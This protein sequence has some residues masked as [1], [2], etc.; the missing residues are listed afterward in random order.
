MKKFFVVL[1]VAGLIAACG[2]PLFAGGIEN[3]TNWS[4]EWV[5]TLNRNAATDSADA[6]AYNPAG[7]MKM[8]N[9][10]YL[11]ASGQYAFKDY[12]STYLGTQY[13]T[14]EPDFVP[15]FFTLYKHDKW[16]AFGAV[17]IVVAGGKVD[18]EHGDYTT[19]R[20]ASGIIA[21]YNASL[22]GAFASILD[23]RLEGKS[24]FVGYTLGGAYKINDMLSV[25]LAA[26][27]VDASRD[28]K[29]YATLGGGLLPT[30]TFGVDY[31]ETGNGWGGIFGINITPIEK[32]NIGLRYETKTSID[33][34][35]H[36]TTDD[37]GIVTEGFQR[38]RDL[39]AV[40]GVGVSYK[41]TPKI[42]VEADL[43][44]YF[45]DD[46]SWEDNPIT[47]GN[48]TVKD[49]GY[50]VGIACEYTFN[51]KWKASVGYM[52]TW[53]GINPDN[54]SIETPELDASTIAGGVAYKPAPNWDLNLGVLKTFYDDATTSYGLHF[55]KDVVIVG[56]GI[57]YKFF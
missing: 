55:E 6:V 18:Y 50:D 16:A 56:L 28:F 42:R 35:T 29:G 23:Q 12:K 30:Q 53:V 41:F 54:M 17:T 39:P 7:V 57:Q 25:S 32:L 37:I 36:V 1:C 5:R 31:E 40:L 22:P 52:Y 19:L 51:P 9:G 43:T 24:Y 11:N 46:A 13:E 34:S 38:S 47:S 10:L 3:K 15:S 8:D 49:D 4:A 26:R 27:Y 20:L 14:D 21:Q 44:Y 33:L 2:S 45:N 48:E